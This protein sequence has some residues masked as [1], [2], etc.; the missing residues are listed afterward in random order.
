MQ[1]LIQTDVLQANSSKLLDGVG[2]AGSGVV[3]THYSADGKNIVTKLDLDITDA[4]TLAD[5]ASLAVGFLAYTFPAGALVVNSS[6]ISVNT[7]NAEQNT[8]AC[9]VGLGTTIG[10]GANAILRGVGAA[11]ENIMTGQTAAIGTAEVKTIGTQLVIE[12]AGDHTVYFNVAG[13]WANTA[14]TDLTADL[15]GSIWLSWT[16][17][18]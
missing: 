4:F 18:S 17:L 9:D 1:D 5:N 7:T 10:S 8:N 15:S 6:S 2:T 14:G 3:A 16:K 12:A 13:A 11:A